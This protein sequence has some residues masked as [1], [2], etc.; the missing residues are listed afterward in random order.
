[1]V[2][3]GHGSHI[4]LMVESLKSTRLGGLLKSSK[5]RVLLRNGAAGTAAVA[6]G[7]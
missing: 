5:T 4:F 6:G 1:M 2:A 7:G 3:R